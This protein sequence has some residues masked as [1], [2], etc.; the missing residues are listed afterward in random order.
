MFKS[1]YSN[2]MSNKLSN[3][4]LIK[5]GTNSINTFT[6]KDESKLH[7]F[8]NRY[9]ISLNIVVIWY[10]KQLI[11]AFS[12]ITKKRFVIHYYGT[13]LHEFLLLLCM[14]PLSATKL[15]CIRYYHKN[16]CVNKKYLKRKWNSHVMT[17][18]VFK[19]STLLDHTST[20]IADSTFVL[21]FIILNYIL[22]CSLMHPRF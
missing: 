10:Q 17:I 16:A 12:C 5:S 13:R 21:F 11:Y 18:I 2:C 8:V 19:E 22:F 14:L 9:F 15:F 3:E 20:F 7:T 1:Y 4:K 6:S